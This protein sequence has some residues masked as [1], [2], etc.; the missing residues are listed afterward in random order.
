MEI[1][2]NILKIITFITFQSLI[3]IT[4]KLY[5]ILYELTTRREDAG[6]IISRVQFCTSRV[7]NNVK[8][9]IVLVKSLIKYRALV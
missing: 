9:I 8:S 2:I 4:F 7:C 1:L 5:F 3:I 6:N